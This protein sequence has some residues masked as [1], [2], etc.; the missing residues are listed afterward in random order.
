MVSIS[1]KLWR[2]EVYKKRGLKVNTGKS[3]VMI[4]VR[5]EG[6]ECEVYVG[7]IHLEHVSEFKYLGCVLEKN[8]L[9]MRKYSRKVMSGKRFASA[10]RS[11]GNA[12]SFQ[13]EFAKVLYESLLIPVLMYVSETMIWRKKEKFK[14]WVVW[15]NNFRGLLGIRR[16]DKVLNA[17]IRQLCRVMEGVNEKI[18]EDVLRWFAH[19]ERMEKDRITKRLCRRVCW[20]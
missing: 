6:L 16:M 15:M 17:Q 19:V 3:K 18:D 12:Q 1:K 9:G 10:F 14:I 7:G 5:K 20:E 13:L 4:L 11:L 8:Q 2:I